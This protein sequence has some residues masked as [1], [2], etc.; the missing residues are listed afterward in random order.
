MK[1]AELLKKL[2]KGKCQLIRHGSSHDI[3][4]SEKT[5][6]KFTVPRHNAEIPTGTANNIMKDAGL[7]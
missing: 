3:W 7:K 2:K 1:T 6:K 5:G 4:Y